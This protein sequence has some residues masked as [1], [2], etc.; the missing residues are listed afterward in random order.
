MNA[1]WWLLLAVVVIALVSA[2]RLL[3]R[4]GL[5][6]EERGWL[7]YK[8]K[9]PSSSPL[10]SLV[11]MQQ[12]LEPGVQHV[13]QAGEERQDEDVSKARERLLACLRAAFSETTV[14]P[15]VVRLYL[16]QARREGLSYEALYEE[17]S[18]GRPAD[19]IPPLSDV[20]PDD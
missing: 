12:F 16:T 15:E 5:W 6:L 4:L 17:A 18:Q 13:V 7:F 8:R 14:N 1:W 20:S 2:L 9:K 11:A 19:Q 10:G 3:D